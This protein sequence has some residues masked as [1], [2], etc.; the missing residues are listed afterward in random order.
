[1]CLNKAMEIKLALSEKM[2][3]G[4]KK[5]SIYAIATRPGVGKTHFCISIATLFASRNQKVLYISNS[6]SE[7]EFFARQQAFISECGDNISF[8]EV[9]KLTLEGF[10]V[11]ASEDD[12]DL[13]VLDPFDI[14]AL[15]IDLGELKEWAKKKNIPILVSKYLSRPPLEDDR[16]HP[17]L[18]DLKFPQESLQEKFLAY[19][20]VILFAYRKAPQSKISLTVAKNIYGTIGTTI[21][22]DK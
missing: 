15:D 5:G 17:V 6:I 8:E 20:D 4:F 14:F 12:Y 19:V 22:V 13:I 16:N 11:F 21:E 2:I 18:S 10:N 7:E 1:M 3:G 9:Y